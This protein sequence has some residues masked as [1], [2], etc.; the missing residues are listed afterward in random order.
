[1]N[2]LNLDKIQNFNSVLFDFDM[3]LVNTKVLINQSILELLQIYFPNK[4]WNLDTI[5]KSNNQSDLRIVLK[6]LLSSQNISIDDKNL[7]NLRIQ[8]KT[9]LAKQDL[10]NSLAPDLEETL[11][12][13]KNT[14][15]NLVIVTTTM[16]KM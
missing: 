12:A 4:I 10:A 7:E 9:I 2:T 6:N 15:K 5:K 1:M 14:N 8:H 13:L 16:Y 11:K 3:T